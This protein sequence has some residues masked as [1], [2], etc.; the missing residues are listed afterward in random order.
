MK[1]LSIVWSG[2]LKCLSFFRFNTSFIN[3]VR[4]L[5]SNSTACVC[6]N[7]YS[8]PYFNIT[9]GVR[10]GC[11][12]SPYIFIICSEI[13]TI[14]IN[15]SLDV[16]GLTILDNEFRISLYADD[17]CIFLDGSYSSL[18]ATVKI[19]HIFEFSSGLKVNYDKSNL[20]PLGPLS[21]KKPRFLRH[22]DFVWTTGPVT[23]LGITF[24]L[25][26]DNLF[27]LN[28]PPKLSRLKNM[29]NM[30]SSRDLTPIGKI[31]II[32][33]FALSQLVYLFQILPNPPPNCIKELNN[34]LYKF[35]WNNKPDKIKR[36][37]MIAPIG[38][39]G[40]KAP[41]VRLFI[42]SLKCSWVHR[43]RSDL[44]NSNWKLFFFFL[45]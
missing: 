5:Y 10:Q 44:T 12:L 38:E 27:R 1:R 37:T 35:I 29:L 21:S 18:R 8:S 17:T 26:P 11:P 25:C 20:F 15:N 39:G 3:W 32:K 36:N 30:W 34:I 14:K 13:L 4:T 33:T 22:F 9:R 2:T 19:L 16:R 41:N 45:S 40:L 28:F 24:D 6:N 7:G 23:V 31:T 43:Y 42:H